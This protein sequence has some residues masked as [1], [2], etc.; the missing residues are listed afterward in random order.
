MSRIVG[1]FLL[2]LALAGA[3][4][5][6]GAHGPDADIQASLAQAT[7]ELQAAGAGFRT[8]Q[9]SDEQIK[10]RLASIAPIE[11]R[12]ATALAN[13]T[14]RLQAAQARLSQLGPA[15]APGQTEDPHTAQLR[16]QLDRTI[17]IFQSDERE[18]RL[19]ALEGRQVGDVLVERLRENFQAR[20]T[21]QNRPLLDP[22]LWR[23]AAAS[24]PG[25]L[26]RLAE[27]VSDEAEAFAGL[28]SRPRDLLT[29][30]LCVG[31]AVLILLPMRI[32]LM[33]LGLRRARR[34]TS[35]SRL[36]RALFALWRVAVGVLT[37]FLALLVLR[38]GLLDAEALTDTADTAAALA[39]R[40]V[41]L[42]VFIEQLGRALLS[43]ARPQWRLAPIS[44][45]SAARLTVFPAL[46]GAA[47]AVATFVAGFNADLGSSQ[48]AQVISDYG[49]VLLE[50]LAVGAAL[51]TAGRVRAARGAVGD[52]PG[53]RLPWVAV[54]LA[55]WI[56]LALAAVA[57]LVGY[58]AFAAFVV[59]EAI[60]VA[61]ILG[62]LLLLLRLADDLI[63]AVL[64]P[65]ARIG[66]ALATGL[67]LSSGSVEQI[68]VLASG[69]ARVMLILLAW[70]AIVAPFGASAGDIFGRVS[71]ASFVLRL[72]K[73][74]VSP[75]EVLGAIAL[76]FVGISATRGVRRWLESRYLPKTQL[77]VGVRTSLAAGVTYLGG[78][79]AILVAFAYLGLSVSQIA[80]FASALS[81]GIG[82]GLQSIIGNF[83][84]GLILLAERPVR[85]GD[86]IAI[87][88]QEGDVRKISIRATEI[89]LTDR[90]RLIVPNTDLISKAVRNVT[91]AGALGRV[92]LVLKVVDSADPAVVHDLVMKRL[93]D[94]PQVLKDP[95]P[96]AYITDV[97]DG[98]IEFTAFAYLETP[99][100]AFRTKSELLF[101]LVPDLRAANIAL[102]STSTIVNVGLG[103]RP[104]EPR[105]PSSTPPAEG[106]GE[107]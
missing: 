54:A 104:I 86:W 19:L 21:S 79:I 6:Q 66:G 16:R 101:Q 100:A 24:A 106:L 51:V 83:V 75:G 74:E 5:A 93:E 52:A 46:I 10:A 95:P 62:L 39:L 77:D 90:S 29:A 11:T 68:A 17:S 81:V 15:P 25:D 14:P 45:E 92:K 89:E 72:G 41:I 105:P 26:S 53:P 1:L 13:L 69:A 43:P 28:V 36:T 87:G 48:S 9:L 23:D 20:L 67:G 91:H 56:A 3:A 34:D 7:S 98:F 32:L 27:F 97:R 64:A 82:F 50:I 4:T 55:G 44:D 71:S 65:S 18:A 47:A 12:L 73:V 40:A 33:G 84:S 96:A 30:A 80:L 60:W 88:D 102:S 49:G 76:L 22:A 61:A 35:H 63:P 31:L 42:G 99:R 94:H 37:P 38:A 58:L 57:M 70:L 78:L 59:R 8:D 2:W 107:T 85:V 103:D